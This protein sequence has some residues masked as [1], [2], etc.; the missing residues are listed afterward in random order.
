MRYAKLSALGMLAASLCCGSAVAQETY[1]PY[2][3]IENRIVS[4]TV[5]DTQ[6]VGFFVG[7]NYDSNVARSDEA[8]AESRGIKRSDEITDIGMNATVIQTLGIQRFFIRGDASYSWYA[9]NHILD[10]AFA[11]F[12]GG[13]T[14]RLGTCEATLQGDYYRRRSDYPVVLPQDISNVRTTGSVGLNLGCGH[15]YGFAPHVSATERWNTNSA[16]IYRFANNQVATVT[17][18]LD[19]RAPVFGSLG[20]YG[21]FDNVRYNEAVLDVEGNLFRDEFD[22]YS[23]GLKYE[24]QFDPRFGVKAIV[25]YTDVN[26]NIPEGPNFQGLTYTFD[27]AYE[28]APQMVAH[29]NF[30]REVLP[31]NEPYATF[32]VQETYEADVSF[33]VRERMRLML[34]GAV[35]HIAFHGTSLFLPAVNLQTQTLYQIRGT[36][37]FM[38]NRRLWFDILASEERGDTDYPGLNFWSTRV[39]ARVRVS[40]GH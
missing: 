28:P 12:S 30:S 3:V 15:K 25:T 1:Q 7:E 17:G 29:A 22:I 23:G 14:L 16:D 21:E 9:N 35:N 6:D 10:T 4:P 37:S 24:K 13:D 2:Q 38:L 27:A 11:H 32:R 19:Y 39:G 36:A 40:F 20:V 33:A 34:D 5:A 18:G 26:S 31:S 8:I